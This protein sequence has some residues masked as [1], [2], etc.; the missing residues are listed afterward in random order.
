MSV[1]H[2]VKAI[3]DRNAQYAEHI[4]S[5]FETRLRNRVTGKTNVEPEKSEISLS[6]LEES[7]MPGFPY[8][9][10]RNKVRG[11]GFI[12][13]LQR[14]AYLFGNNSPF[15]EPN[16]IH[17]ARE[18]FEESGYRTE[19]S[20]NFRETQWIVEDIQEK[21]KILHRLKVPLESIN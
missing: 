2:L 20:A 5:D 14:R 1:H 3:E 4:R 6:N 11:L 16:W 21:E 13:P 10:L 9:S 18:V 15:I 17:Q 8:I 19:I 12:F 7:N